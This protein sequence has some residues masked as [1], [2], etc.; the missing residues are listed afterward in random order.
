MLEDFRNLTTI[1]EYNDPNTHSKATSL[2]KLFKPMDTPKDGQKLVLLFKLLTL[3][4]DK[5]DID[6]SLYVESVEKYI[7][8]A[9]DKSTNIDEHAYLLP[10]VIFFQK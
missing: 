10:L 6:V 8:W 5:V 9:L 2:I 4:K 1:Y 7:N 3:T